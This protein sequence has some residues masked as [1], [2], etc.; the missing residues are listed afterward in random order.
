MI[1]RRNVRKAERGQVLIMC[2]VSMLVL[3]LF[4]GFAIDFGVAYV[5]KAQLGKASDAAAL[6]AARYSAQGATKAEA[7][8]QSAFAMN[9]NSSS[10]DYTAAPT[11][12][13]TR[14]TDTGGDTVFTVNTSATTK[15]FFTGL[16]PGFAT[17]NV[18]N[19][20]QSVAARV[21]MTIVL[22]RSGS[23]S[24]DG[25][26]TNLPTAVSDFITYFDDTYDSVA[27]VTFATYPTTVMTM[28]TGNF[29]ALVT[30]DASSINWGGNTYSDGALQQAF[31]Q[32][33]QPVTG[34]VKKVVV[35]FTDG[36]ANMIENSLACGTPSR[37]T[38]GTWNI[39]GQ[40]PP[41]T[42]VGF[43]NPTTGA[44]SG[45]YINES[46]CCTNPGTFPSAS[47]G[48]T[49][50]PAWTA[51]GPVVTPW[52]TTGPQVPITYANVQADALYRAIGDAN[53]MR[54]Q[55][56][57]VYSIGLGSAPAPADP[58]FLCQVAND[59]S[60]S[61]TYNPNLPTGVMEYAPTGADLA[62]AFQQIASIIRLRLTQ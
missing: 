40:D 43:M 53:A 8:A 34:N 32:E 3:L 60:C 30:Q 42:D 4:V 61:P 35:F 31:T 6:V 16:L 27:L 28:R 26:S 22:D 62:P 17:M 19:S 14:S 55:G 18:V 9:Y 7:M 24:S 51:A 11:V 5:T 38:S 46:I 10:L 50:A 23:M 57:T 29:Q 45:C 52:N 37:L 15:T 49:V 41:S 47:Q 58:T 44:D 48:S 13:V 2:A 25:G 33:M 39:G 1:T 12:T 20:A 59:S 21:E 36:G 56:I 54:A